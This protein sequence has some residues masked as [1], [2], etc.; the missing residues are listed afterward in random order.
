MIPLAGQTLKTGHL[1]QPTASA[2]GQSVMIGLPGNSAA[3][4]HAAISRMVLRRAPDRGSRFFHARFSLFNFA[5]GLMG[6][7]QTMTT[8]S[9][10][11]ATR[12]GERRAPSQGPSKQN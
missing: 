9:P 5:P 2:T 8:V 1:M 7:P 12:M 4:L 3:G 10:R 11:R 6:I